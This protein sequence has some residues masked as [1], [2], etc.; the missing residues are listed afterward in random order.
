MP[1]ARAAGRTAGT[2]ARRSA[3]AGTAGGSTA[4][5]SVPPINI[6]FKQPVTNAVVIIRVNSPGDDGRITQAVLERLVKKALAKSAAAPAVASVGPARTVGRHRRRGAHDTSARRKHAHARAPARVAP[7]AAVPAA[8]ATPPPVIAPAVR[9][10][11][12][13]QR[14]RSGTRQRQRHASAP[15]P[16]RDLRVPLAA[17]NAAVASAGPGGAGSGSTAVAAMLAII[18]LLTPTLTRGLRLVADGP[19][20]EPVLVVRDHPG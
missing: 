2:P 18:V 16:E 4:A 10:P 17:E 6:V 14:A 7:V 8:V 5:G 15:R 19:P 12:A 13:P 20:A 11:A 3:A 1:A 9:R